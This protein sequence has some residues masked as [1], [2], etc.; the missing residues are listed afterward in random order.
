[1][2]PKC[3]VSFLPITLNGGGKFLTFQV[4]AERNEGG[5]KSPSFRV[6]RGFSSYIG[7]EQTL[8]F[9]RFLYDMIMIIPLFRN[10]NFCSLQGRGNFLSLCTNKTESW[11]QRYLPSPYRGENLAFHRD[12]SRRFRG[13]RW[14]WNSRSFML[15][16]QVSGLIRERR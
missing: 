10:A 12:K 1:M 14:T 9:F 3:Q 6:F 4:S 8:A 16:L 5:R 7:R 11:K 2:T 15:R 13:I